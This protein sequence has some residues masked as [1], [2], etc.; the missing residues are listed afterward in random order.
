[1][2]KFYLNIEHRFELLTAFATR[3]LGNSISFLVAFFLVLFWWANDFFSNPTIHQIIGDFIFGVTFLSLFIIQKSFN[4]HSAMIHLKM[5]ELISSHENANNAVMNT[6]QKSERE[7]IQLHQDYVAI[8]EA[9]H[10]ELEELE[11]KEITTD[12]QI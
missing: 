9:L 3:V 1:M 7:I 12:N 2:N 8:E 10:H 5:N 11:A 4:R 6:D